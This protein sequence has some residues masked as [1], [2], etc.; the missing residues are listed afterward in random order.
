MDLAKIAK[1]LQAALCRK[2]RPVRIDRLQYY[3]EKNGR[4]GTMYRV[5]ETV[6]DDDTGKKRTEVH[7]KGT[8]LVEVVVILRALYEGG[9]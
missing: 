6:V 2:G 4:I 1:R 8:R 5:C 9:E 3:S 7:Y